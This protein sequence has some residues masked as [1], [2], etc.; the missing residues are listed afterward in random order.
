[1]PLEEIV[2]CASLYEEFDSLCIVNGYYVTN[3]ADSE[4]NKTLKHAEDSI[5]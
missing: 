3:V 1:M 2:S 4:H 5:Q